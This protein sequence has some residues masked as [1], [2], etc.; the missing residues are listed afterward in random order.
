VRLRRAVDA[1]NLPG[2]AATLFHNR[3]FPRPDTPER[4]KPFLGRFTLQLV[5]LRHAEYRIS[6]RLPV[7][8]RANHFDIAADLAFIA[9]Q[10]G[11]IVTAVA[12]VEPQRMTLR[13]GRFPLLTVNDVG[14]R[15]R[16]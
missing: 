9:H 12:Q 10:Q 16:G 5:M 15:V 3:F 11:D 4:G 8:P 6:Q 14:E 7:L 2:A 13:K 1:D